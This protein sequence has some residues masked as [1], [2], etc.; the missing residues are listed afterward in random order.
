MGYH[1]GAWEPDLPLEHI[2]EHM[3]CTLMFSITFLCINTIK[4][5]H[6]LRQVALRRFNKNMVMVIHQTPGMTSPVKPAA[7]LRKHIQPDLTI[8]TIMEDI[9][10]LITP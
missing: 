2:L 6:P 4:L 10:S 8:L 7:H 3:A 5:A 1:A 9:F